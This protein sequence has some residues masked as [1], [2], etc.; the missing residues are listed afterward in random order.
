M[1]LLKKFTPY[2]FQGMFGKTVIWKF[3][4]IH[5]KTALVEF[6]LSNLSFLTYHE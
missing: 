5:R 6:Q 4:K 2:I 1:L 3:R